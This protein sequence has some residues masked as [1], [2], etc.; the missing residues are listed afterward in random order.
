[1][2]SP[3]VTPEGSGNGQETTLEQLSSRLDGLQKATEDR[4]RQ[5]E[6]EVATRRNYEKVVI[7]LGYGAIALIAVLGFIGYSNVSDIDSKVS[8]RID[9]L[10][11]RSDGQKSATLDNFVIY[12]KRMDE[13]FSSLGDAEEAW[14]NV[15]EPKLDQLKGYDPDADLQGRYVV[16]MEDAENDARDEKAWRE[17]ATAVIAQAIEH[18]QQTQ[19]D[20]NFVAQF[21]PDQIFNLA[22]IS[23]QLGRNDL[24]YSLTRSA[25]EAKKSSAAAEALFLQSEARRLDVEAG[26]NPAFRNLLG[27]VENLSLDNP[28]IVIAEAWNAAESLREYTALIEV[29]DSLIQRQREDSTVFLPSYAFV[30]KGQAHQRRGLSGDMLAAVMAYAAGVERLSIEGLWSQWGEATY[31]ELLESVQYLFMS[32]VDTTELDDAVNA[33]GISPLQVPYEVLR[34]VSGADEFSELTAN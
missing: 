22:Q 1:M 13:L 26:S 30:I 28:Q 2:T 20:A 12:N 33:S 31:G 15:I 4:V 24:E 23:R 19:Q 32:D 7:L 3:T 6:L 21:S 29:I 27:L 8:E 16:V 10:I 18:I 9:L 34:L 11:S 14:T 25:Y 17:L 5:V